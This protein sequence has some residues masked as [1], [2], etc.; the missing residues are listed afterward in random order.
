MS[1]NNKTIELSERNKVGLSFL[2]LL[3]GRDVSPNGELTES[4]DLKENMR[5][6]ARVLDPEEVRKLNKDEKALHLINVRQD[7]KDVS[8]YINDANIARAMKVHYSPTNMSGIVRAMSQIN[9]FLSN[10]NTSW[11]PSFV[12]PN[13]AKDLSLIH[14]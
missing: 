13:L 5:A 10:V 7:G 9:R 3:N 6:I 11:N 14:I 2:S 1:Q 8:I 4:A 12:I